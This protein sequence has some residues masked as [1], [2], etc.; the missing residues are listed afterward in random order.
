MMLHTIQCTWLPHRKN[1]L[2]KMTYTMVEKF[3]FRII[4]IHCILYSSQESVEGKR[5]KERERKNI[6]NPIYV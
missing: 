1:E 5:E 3:C 4:V 6:I 2:V